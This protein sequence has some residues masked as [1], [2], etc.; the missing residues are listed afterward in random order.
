MA[1]SQ[2]GSDSIPAQSDRAFALPDRDVP[3]P[4]RETVGSAEAL[5][6]RANLILPSANAEDSDELRSLITELQKAVTARDPDAIRFVSREME[7]L[8]FYLEDA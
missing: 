3:L 4:L 6:A 7:D 2:A 1:F 8:I 5:L